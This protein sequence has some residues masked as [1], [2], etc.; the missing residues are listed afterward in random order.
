MNINCL[1]RDTS[2]I[3]DVQDAIK[4]LVGDNVQNG[5][6]V[7][8]PSVYSE[9]REA[10]LEIDAE[11]VGFLYNN[12]YGGYNDKLLS[13]TSEVEKFVG[14]DVELQLKA[15]VDGMNQVPPST[16]VNSIGRNAPEVQV[17][18]MLANMF[19][20][21]AFPATKNVNTVLKQMET[22]VGRA[23]RTLLPP[24]SRQ[25]SKSLQDNLND[26]F[27]TEANKFRTLSGGVNTLETLYDAVKTEIDNYVQEAADRLGD[28]EADLLRQQWDAYFKEF[29]AGGYDIMLGKSDQNKLLNEALKQI[30]VNGLQIV[31]VNGNIK[32]KT[33]ME[34]NDP[35]KISD[36]VKKLFENG[37]QDETGVVHKYKPEEAERI[38]NYFERLY[39]NK[40]AA[41]KQ[42]SNGNKRTSQTSAKNIISDFIKDRGFVNLVKDKDGNL[43]LTQAD[44]DRALKYM[45]DKSGSRNGDV[46]LPELEKFLLGLKDQNGNPK[47]NQRQIEIIKKEFQQTVAAKLLPGTAKPGAMDRLIA[48]NN[49]NGGDLFNEQKQFAINDIVGV[50]GLNQN[51]LNQIKQLVQAA[52]Q[53]R[54]GNNVPLNPNTSGNPVKSRGAYA[55]QVLSQ[56]ERKIREIVRVN[57]IDRSTAQGIVKY[58]GDVFGAAS[59]SLLINPGNVGENIVTG[60]ASNIAESIN[61]LTTKPALLKRLFKDGNFWSAWAS[62]VTGGVANEVIVDADISSD[63]QA[64]ERLRLNNWRRELA[65]LKSGDISAILKTP[66]YAI[67]IFSRSI[68][69]SFD[70][71]FNSSLMRK[72]AMLSVY[73]SLRAQ[74]MSGDET[75]SVMDQALNITPKVNAEL[76]AEN[77]AIAQM[78]KSVGINPTSA[79]MALNKRDMKLA[80]YEDVLRDGAMLQG[81]KTSDKIISESAKALIDSASLQAKDLGGKKQLPVG[82][83]DFLNKLI[84]QGAHGLLFFQREFFKAQQVA[85]EE[86]RLGAAAKNQAF[87]E[88]YKNTIGRFAGG[89]ANFM[90]L[91]VT[92]TPLGFLSAMSLSQQARKELRKNPDAADVFKGDPGDIRKYAEYHNLVRS[93]VVRATMGSLAIAAWAVFGG[94]DSDDDDFIT[95]LMQTKSGRR[96]L[97]KYAPMGLNMAFAIMY[98]VDDPKFDTWWERTLDVLGN[99]TGNSYDSWSNLKTQVSRAKSDQNRFRALGSVFSGLTPTFNINQ[100]EQLTKFFTTLESGFNRDAIKDVK[101]NEA[102]ASQVY[103]DAETFGEAWLVNGIIDF[104]ARGGKNRYQ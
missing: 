15:I 13:N 38:G 61:I 60:L 83:L 84:Y 71:G 43:L 28:T 41:V 92:S 35:D 74:G 47:F 80:L 48:I 62:H 53:I 58:I 20:R 67:S 14:K 24:T 56:I 8:F 66:A 32:W 72:K 70:A 29:M 69:N 50:S 55:F 31:D 27:T 94:G 89:I 95:N 5:K 54:L 49:I 90:A 7:K 33:L 73:N 17:A 10:G 30:E 23:A 1:Y 36:A 25:A 98:D 68:M 44:W 75:L 82:T 21:D 85:E 103:K 42:A 104:I 11:S 9:I 18:T 91:A 46:L 2:I 99:T 45:Q 19:Q 96:L 87:A 88:L 22:L 93:M 12:L 64:G 102:I 79:D 57:K 3:N 39:K 52:H 81:L 76:D 100:A 16:N 86:G 26:F 6:S 51:V 37:V 59:T 65:K 77:K 40:L 78:L 63:L 4:I 34:D 97:Q 101:R